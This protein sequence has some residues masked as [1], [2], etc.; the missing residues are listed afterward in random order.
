MKKENEKH[1]SVPHEILSDRGVRL[2]QAHQAQQNS[3]TN[4]NQRVIIGQLDDSGKDIRVPIGTKCP[5]C[6]KRVRGL[7]HANG[8]HHLGTGIR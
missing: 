2:E 1:G 3:N 6:K 7:N 5:K 8:A 4:Y